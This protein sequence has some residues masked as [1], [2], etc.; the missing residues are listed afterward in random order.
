M[1][2][3]HVEDVAAVLGC[4]AGLLVQQGGKLL[5]TGL[6]RLHFSPHLCFC[7][8]CHASPLLPAVCLD[9]VNSTERQQAIS[10]GQLP[11]SFSLILAHMVLHHV[12]DVAA[13]LGCLAWLLQPGGKLLLTDLFQTERSKAFHGA[14]A[15]HTVSHAGMGAIGASVHTK[16][17]AAAAAAAE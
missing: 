1:V 15:H 17:A 14:T 2:L 11:S 13:V 16:S 12:E 8:A 10:S 7:P 5:L 9:L 6:L 4:L 3:H